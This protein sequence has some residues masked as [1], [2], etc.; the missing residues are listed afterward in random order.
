MG[1]V[2]A[3]VPGM[4]EEGEQ[5]L[6]IAGGGVLLRLPLALSQ[7]GQQGI[8]ILHRQLRLLCL[9]PHPQ[10]VRWVLLPPQLHHLR[11]CN[12]LHATA[13][14]GSALAPDTAAARP[15]T[16]VPSPA[17]SPHYEIL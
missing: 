5:Q 7:Q 11:L 15:M 14:S 16:S 1:S 12:D 6:H 13:I 9:Q 4:L 8:Q 2:T 3:S 17:A 10:R